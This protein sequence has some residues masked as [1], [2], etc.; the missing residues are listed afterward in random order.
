M[1]RFLLVTVLLKL[2][3]FLQ[4]S[5]ALKVVLPP[6]GEKGNPSDYI[7]FKSLQYALFLTCFVEVIGGVFFLLTAI[8]IV[9]DKLKVDRAIAGEWI[10]SF[11][12]NL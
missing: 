7:D 1:R 10:Y 9:R 5:E 12:R 4:I 2:L 11:L 6:I 8:Y 3:F